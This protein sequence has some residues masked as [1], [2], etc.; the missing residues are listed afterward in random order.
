MSKSRAS[1]ALAI[2]SF[3]WGTT[4]FVS[5]LTVAHIPPLQMTAV[6]QT[7]AGIL[8]VVFF[9]LKGKKIPPL[10]DLLFYLLMGFLLISCSNGLTTWAIKYIPS[11]L[12]ALISALMPFVMVLATFVFFR[13][14]IKPLAILGLVMGFAGVA[15]LLSSFYEE[16]S[17]PNFMFGVFLTLIGVLTWT[18]GTLL[19]IH[20]K[21][22][23]DPYSGIG[24]QMLF[25][26]IILYGAS[27]V[28]G[29][30]IPLHTVPHTAWLS[31]AYL[32]VVGSILCFMCYLYALKHL[33]ISLVSIYVYIN[34]LVALLM[35][36]IFLNEKL[37]W[38]IV[39][40]ALTIIGGIYIVKRSAGN[41]ASDTD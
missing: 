34:P 21:R 5:K 39:I 18:T 36:V 23:L 8:V 9:L 26:G 41:E 33:P 7:V 30:H 22:K 14:K 12:G 29:Q 31:I 13:E 20:N 28:S 6:R 40:G 15:F 3:F 19:T 24:W 17:N 38:P 11:Y 2:I 27:L 16:L 35:G 1:G 10:R 32:I 37:G 4:W 25:G